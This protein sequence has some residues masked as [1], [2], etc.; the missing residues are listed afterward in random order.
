MKLLVFLLGVIDLASVSR[1]ERELGG[2]EECVY[3]LWSVHGSIREWLE[4]RYIGIS[5]TGYGTAGKPRVGWVWPVQMQRGN[6]SARKD[7]YGG[8]VAMFN[9]ILSCVM[10]HHI[11]ISS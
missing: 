2:L 4:V 11:I 3:W 5:P 7:Y 9:S 10:C 6:M 8:D 1:I